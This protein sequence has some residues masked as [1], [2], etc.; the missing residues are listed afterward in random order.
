MSIEAFVNQAKLYL[1][2]NGG[3]ILSAVII[4]LIGYLLIKLTM[5]L[6]NKALEK[7]RINVSAHSL[8]K[9]ILKFGLYTVL[10]IICASKLNIDTTSI[11]AVLGTAG[12]ALSLAVKDTLGN[13]AGGLIV[14]FTKP[15]NVGDFIETDGVS[16]TVTEISF[17]YT[18]LNT[19]DNKR[20]FIPNGE[21]TNAQIINY[22]AEEQRRLDL[23]FSI[24]YDDDFRKAEALIAKIIED[25]PHTLSEPAPIIRVTEHGPNAIII[26][27]RVWVKSEHY[28]DLY[29]DMLELV[30]ES[31]DKN[32]I[33]IPN[34][35]Y[36]TEGKS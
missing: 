9:T 20:I 4:L 14:L 36:V 30:K 8:I 10:F 2:K 34:V 23:D 24:S 28:W 29:Y 13:L 21:V 7:S 1:E 35:I 31:F 3:N 32:G 18:R 25:H 19:I 26:A 27:M 5:R 33:T 15:F 17:F 6:T 11:I 16:G 22:S 12:L